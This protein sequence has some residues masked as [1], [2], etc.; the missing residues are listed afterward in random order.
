[1]DRF[2]EIQVPTWD[3]G[4][5]N[6]E[7]ARERQAQVARAYE[8]IAARAKTVAGLMRLRLPAALML[9]L[10]AVAAVAAPMTHQR[11]A[12]LDAYIE[13]STVTEARASGRRAVPLRT[14]T[15]GAV[16]VDNQTALRDAGYRYAS[17]T[18]LTREDAMR[19]AGMQYASPNEDVVRVVARA[20]PIRRSRRIARQTSSNIEPISGPMLSFEEDGRMVLIPDQNQ[21]LL[22]QIP[23]GLDGILVRDQSG[24]EVFVNRTTGVQTVA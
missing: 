12:E 4:P 17:P 18:E 16:L 14:N 24:Q 7:E 3:M 23:E 9:G 19:V 15:A 8:Q 2:W 6:A 11:R 1:M 13:N 20:E 10:A 22:S 5:H 21:E